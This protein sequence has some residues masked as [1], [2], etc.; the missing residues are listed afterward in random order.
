MY[1]YTVKYL[2]FK[3]QHIVHAQTLRRE[4]SFVDIT[5]VFTVFQIRDELMFRWWRRQTEQW[6]Q[7]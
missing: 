5:E 3:R 6:R 4:T 7:N 2:L 1:I